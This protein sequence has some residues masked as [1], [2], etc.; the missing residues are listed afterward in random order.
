MNLQGGTMKDFESEHEKHCCHG[1]FHHEECH[2]GDH[3]H[4]EEAK[5]DYFLKL[6]DEAWQEVLKDKIKEYILE[7]QGDRMGKLAKIVAE[8]NHQ[9]WRNRMQQKQGC[10]DFMAEL[11]KFF[12]Q[13]KK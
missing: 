3:E 2:H 10:K 5:T 8:G 4:Q 9:R 6:A 11:C 13:M 12:D 1:H 7:T